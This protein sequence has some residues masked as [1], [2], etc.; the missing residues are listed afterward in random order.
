EI[1]TILSSNP[2]LTGR[3]V[4]SGAF[5]FGR[6]CTNG[7]CVKAFSRHHGARQIFCEE[8]E[9]VH[10]RS[11]RRGYYADGPTVT[12]R[13]RCTKLGLHWPSWPLWSIRHWRRTTTRTS[14]SA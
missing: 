8:R 3:I 12:G 14:P 11:P 5:W 10:V 13:E 9:P 1:S 2:H 4:P 7:P 6:A